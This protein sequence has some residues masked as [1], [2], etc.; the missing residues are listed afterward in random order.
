MH[1]KI[2]FLINISNKSQYQLGK[3]LNKERITIIIPNTFLIFKVYLKQH[4]QIS[5]SKISDD[6]K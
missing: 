5:N 3:D 2:Q 4:L 1:L 6:L